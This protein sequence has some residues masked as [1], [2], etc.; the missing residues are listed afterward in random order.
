MTTFQRA[1]ASTAIPIIAL[2]I[3]STGDLYFVWFLAA[4]IGVIALFT[5]IGFAIGGKRSTASGTLAGFGV[6]F[7]ALTVTCFANLATF[8]FQ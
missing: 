6:G 4:F 1:F 8:E 5:A 3:L 7:L 2:S